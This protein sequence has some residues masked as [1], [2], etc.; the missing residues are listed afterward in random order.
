MVLVVPSIL[1]RN[2]D[3]DRLESKKQTDAQSELD[4]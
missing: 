4:L 2:C 1:L 3:L